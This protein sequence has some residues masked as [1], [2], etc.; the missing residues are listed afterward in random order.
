MFLTHAKNSDNILAQLGSVK[1][2]GERISVSMG[3]DEQEDVMV[4]K[5][6]EIHLKRIKEVFTKDDD[7]K[8]EDAEIVFVYNAY[9]EMDHCYYLTV[10][11]KPLNG[12]E[13]ESVELFINEDTIP[14]LPLT[15]KPIAKCD[16][17]EFG[18]FNEHTVSQVFSYPT[19]SVF[20]KNCETPLVG[21]NF[22]EDGVIEAAEPDENT[23]FDDIDKLIGELDS[24]FS[25]LLQEN[26]KNQIKQIIK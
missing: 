10:K 3:F 17:L 4:D 11:D 20:L 13:C 2:N 14:Y 19:V 12:L 21:L 23:Y 22:W 9:S 5:I 8:Y 24:K 7:S 1:I 25:Q 15:A 18:L 16:G 6:N 26:I